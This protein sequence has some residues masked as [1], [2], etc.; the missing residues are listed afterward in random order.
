MVVL[1]LATTALVVT[2][3]RSSDDVAAPPTTASTPTDQSS[4][5]TESSPRE[6]TAGPTEWC[7][8]PDPDA[9]PATTGPANDGTTPED[10]QAEV[11]DISR[12]V[13][14]ERG[15]TFDHPVPV[16]TL[17]ADDFKARVL[18]EFQ[19]DSDVLEAQGAL[20]RAGGIVTP[21]VD[22]VQSQL[23][24]LADGVLGFYDPVSEELVVRRDSAGPMVRS[25]MAHELTHALDDQ[26]FGL[27]RPELAE[28]HDGSDW[29]FLALVEGSAKR[30][31]TAYLDQ[32]SPEDQDQ[33]AADQLQL[34][35]DQIK[36]L[37]STPLVLA[38]ILMSPYDYGAPFVEALIDACGTARLDEAFGA[39]PV[40]SEQVLDPTR[41]D[42]DRPLAVDQP[43]ADGE[44]VDQGV[45]G[46][47]LTGFLVTEH[48]SIDSMLGGVDPS[49]IED[50]LDQLDPET[51]REM[52]DQLEQDGGGAGGIGGPDALGSGFPAVATTPDWGGDH[53]VV[54]RTGGQV[55]LRADWVM[56][57]PEALATFRDVLA[58]WAARDSA[59][60]LADPTPDST[61]V[62][63]CTTD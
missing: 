29:A 38:Q 59:V 55:C 4:P 39:P 56:D 2:R 32:L 60:V 16:A 54:W 9:P 40:S 46:Q 34:G 8:E 19:T 5:T 22:V 24:L 49:Q 27:D 11:D 52:M 63:R 14:Q 58:T 6:G 57:A 47:L 61:R 30:V 41:F 48:T 7:V 15:L 10:V 37:F 3:T 51:L 20:L 13:E 62:T 53:Y 12:F 17:G 21:D 25:V 44:V 23:D 50:L 18:E 35:I 42:G 33:L 31:E 26:H 1:A 45:L 43:P 28:R 36:T